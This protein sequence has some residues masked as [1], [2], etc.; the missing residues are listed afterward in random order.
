MDLFI[1][2]KWRAAIV[3]GKKMPHD[4]AEPYLA[5][6]YYLLPPQFFP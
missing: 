5:K 6:R 3:L 1:A 4:R 2:K